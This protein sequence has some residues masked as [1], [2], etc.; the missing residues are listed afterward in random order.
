MKEVKADALWLS[1]KAGI[2]EITALRIAVLEWQSRPSARLLARF[3]D[4]ETTSVQSATGADN[5]RVSLAGP[6]LTEILRQKPG[7]EDNSSF[8]SEESRRFRLRNLYLSERSHVVKTSRK[9]FALSLHDSTQDE[10]P[11]S[12][13]DGTDRRRSLCKLG[14]AIYKDESSGDYWRQFLQ[15]CI[16]AVRDRL[17]AL[18]GDGGWLGAAECSEELEDV[19]RTIITEEIVHILQILFLELQ[20]STEIPTADLLLSW[21]RLMANYS[22]L[23]SLQVVSRFSTRPL[24]ACG[25]I[26]V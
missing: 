7:R 16:D 17:S 25:H 15:K 13:K 12:E 5:F 21:L 19:W 11:V 8:A 22:F 3:S 10:P 4:E 23:E 24:L 6:N 20:A 14:E 1:Q 26:R 18:E 9:L 2:D